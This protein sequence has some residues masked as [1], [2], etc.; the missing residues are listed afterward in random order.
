MNNNQLFE[1]AIIGCDTELR[2][3]LTERNEIIIQMKCNQK[4]TMDYVL[5]ILKELRSDKKFMENFH[6]QDLW[7]GCGIE[8][9]H[10]KKKFTLTFMD[11]IHFHEIMGV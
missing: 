5:E 11:A 3:S 8:L 2:F 9:E 7:D 1:M 10:R 6:K 4:F